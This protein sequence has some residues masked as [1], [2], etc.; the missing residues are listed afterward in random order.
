MVP[1]ADIDAASAGLQ[2]A[3]FTNLCY[4]GLSG[5]RG[6]A[7]MVETDQTVKRNNFAGSA[8]APGL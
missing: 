2:P 1:G 5:Q 6:G 7:A 3:A 4:P 8:K